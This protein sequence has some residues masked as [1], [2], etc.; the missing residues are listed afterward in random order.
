MEGG[1]MIMPVKPLLV[2]LGA[3]IRWDGKTMTLTATKGGKTV[4]LTVGKPSML[5]G[6]Q[7]EAVLAPRLQESTMVAEPR[8]IVEG[9]GGSVRW[10][11]V[12]N[13]LFVQS[14]PE[15]PEAPPEPAAEG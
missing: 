5:V 13:T 7:P 10:D 3:S 14:T 9:L 11:P 15:A 8:P 1:R 4:A 12:R 2:A 6:G